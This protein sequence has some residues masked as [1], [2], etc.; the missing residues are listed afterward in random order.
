MLL[1]YRTSVIYL[2]PSCGAAVPSVRW[3]GPDSGMP[4]AVSLVPAS[5]GACAVSG[6]VH[7]EP[8]DTWNR[9]ACPAGL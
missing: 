4:S 8:A 3:S 1:L 7:Y 9:R 2:V 5:Y 6:D